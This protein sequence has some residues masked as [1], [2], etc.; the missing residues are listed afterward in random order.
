[1]MATVALAGLADPGAAVVVVDAQVDDPSRS[2]PAFVATSGGALEA[3][4]TQTTI[5]ANV[6]AGPN[7]SHPDTEA[8]ALLSPDQGA[9]PPSQAAGGVANLT[10]DGNA[11]DGWNATFPDWRPS[12]DGPWR[13]VGLDASGNRTSFQAN[14]SVAHAPDDVLDVSGPATVPFSRGNVTVDVAVGNNRTGQPAAGATLSFPGRPA[15]VGGDGTAG[16]AIDTRTSGA[17]DY[18]VD[19]SR[20]TD[21]DGLSDVVGA[22]KV[23]VVPADLA[24]RNVTDRPKENTK[25]AMALTPIESE[26]SASALAASPLADGDVLNAT[27]RLVVDGTVA[28]TLNPSSAWTGNLTDGNLTLTDGGRVVVERKWTWETHRIEAT[29]EVAGDDRP[30]HH[31][32]HTFRPLDVTPPEVSLSGPTDVDEDTDANF[33]ANAS[34]NHDVTAIEWSVGG[35]AATGANVNDAFEDP[36]THEV[37]VTARD[38]DGNTDE[39]TLEVNV[40]DTTAPEVATGGARTVHAGDPVTFDASDTDENGAIASVEWALGDGGVV[41]GTEVH[42]TYT[43][44]GTYTVTVAVTDEGGNS[45]STSFEVTVE[46]GDAA[47]EVANTSLGR[48]R[49]PAGGSATVQVAVG[50]V[51][52]EDGVHDLR[53]QTDG[54]TLDQE[55]VAVDAGSQVNTTLTATLDEPGDHDLQVGTASAGTLQVVTPPLVTVDDRVDDGTHH[56]DVTVGAA[57]PG[58]AVRV[59]PSD[60]AGRTGGSSAP[61]VLHHLNMTSTSEG[62]WSVSVSATPTPD[63]DAVDGVPPAARLEVA[64]D[65]D[66]VG[67]WNATLSADPTTLADN[68]GNRSPAL[69]PTSGPEVDLDPRSRGDWT[70]LVGGSTSAQE[71]LLGPA[72]AETTIRDLTV[73]P[74]SVSPGEAVRVTATVAKHGTGSGAATLDLLVGGTVV[75]SETV[76]MEG[77]KDEA[78]VTMSH[79]VEET[80]THTVAV[81]DAQATVTVASATDGGDAATAEASS[82]SSAEDE[83]AAETTSIPGSGAAA[84]V[85][86]GLAGALATRHRPR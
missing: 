53:L 48:D 60:L 47:F 21:G 10:A 4:E 24:T 18:A 86:A 17:H 35:D 63:A 20:D 32:N 46:P 23:P 27:V 44:A 41:T 6:S 54:R 1:M 3:D 80:G 52:A 39:A 76:A 69:H 30:E 72:T 82:P 11:T 29:T 2:D 33:T 45:A 83:T 65:A 36:G 12:T 34:D 55:S 77:S 15:T 28:A 79:V 58:D 31:L 51:G 67:T 43:D 42:H 50:N 84:V 61:V 49:V 62:N 66:A 19:A 74:T 68:L 64:G 9:V 5:L 81:G 59:R 7:G 25:E 70:H 85:V 22:T 40:R 78:T 57:E 8:V 75:G 16:I 14:V 71:M 38:A 56:V 73:D 13:F 37:T 26:R